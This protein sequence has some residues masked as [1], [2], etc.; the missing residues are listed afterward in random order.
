MPECPNEAISQGDDV[1]LIDADRC[2]ECVGFFAKEACQSVCPVECCVTDQKHAETE[3][4]LIARALAL[5]P[6][7]KQLAEQVAQGKFPSRY[8]A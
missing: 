5:H 2:T 6:E 8:R 3:A 1:Y 4:V 7:K